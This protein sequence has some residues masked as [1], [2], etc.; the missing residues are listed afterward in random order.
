M[1]KNLKFSWMENTINRIWNLY[2]NSIIDKLKGLR[3]L[4]LFEEYKFKILDGFFKK[5]VDEVECFEFFIKNEFFKFEWDKLINFIEF[6]F[7]L[8]KNEFNGFYYD[9][10]YGFRI[11]LRDECPEC[12]IIDDKIDCNIGDNQFSEYIEV[13][14]KTD[15]IFNSCKLH[16]SL[17]QE[18]LKN[19]HFSNSIKESISAVESICKTISK[20]PNSSLGDALDK[21]KVKLYINKALSSGFKSIYGY[22]S[23]DGG[24]RHAL[25]DGQTIPD[26][27][28]AKFMLA[29]CAAFVNYL[30]VKANKAKIF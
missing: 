24:I 28:D 23:N 17:A 4:S 20:S 9:F 27:E 25:V 12:I 6:N 15:E 21:I 10:I 11:I 1:E 14:S 2:M 16:L 3:H 30:I 18:L 29:S 8:I 19:K 7:S 13:L 5:R 26:L 22:T